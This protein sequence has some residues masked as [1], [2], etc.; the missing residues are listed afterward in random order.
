MLLVA[1]DPSMTKQ[2]TVV[3]RNPSAVRD[4]Y[5]TVYGDA[6]RFADETDWKG[7]LDNSSYQK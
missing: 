5:V 4:A 6:A 7:F 1:F 3:D 2:V